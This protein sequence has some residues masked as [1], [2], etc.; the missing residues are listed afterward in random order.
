MPIIQT[1]VP[2][3]TPERLYGAVEGISVTPSDSTD[4][5]ITFS[6][7]IYIGGAGDLTVTMFNG[8]DITFKA[9]PVGSLLPVCARRIKATGTTA[10]NI[11]ALR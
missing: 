6:R 11:L 1:T 4:L 8:G 3:E 10:T 9:V 5:S 7:A 2:V